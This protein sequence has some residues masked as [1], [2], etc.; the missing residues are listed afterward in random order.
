MYGPQISGRRVFRA[1][2]IAGTKALRQ[3][4]RTY[5]KVAGVAGAKWGIQTVCLLASK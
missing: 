3:T 2:E 1:E 4:Y 5:S